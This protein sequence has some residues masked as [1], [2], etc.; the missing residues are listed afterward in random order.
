[1]NGGLDHNVRRPIINRGIM[2]VELMIAMVLGL[3]VIAGVGS[4]FLANKQAYQ[5]SE[6]LS[7]YQENVRY[8][9]EMITKDIRQADG[10]P[11][12]KRDSKFG[13]QSSIIGL[14]WGSGIRGYTSNESAESKDPPFGTGTADRIRGTDALRVTGSTGKIYKVTQHSGDVFSL[15]GNPNGSF[16]IAC[17][18]DSATVFKATVNNSTLTDSS[19]TTS[20]QYLQDSQI[21]GFSQAFWYLGC[22]GLASCDSADGRSIYRAKNNLASSGGESPNPIVNGVKSLQFEYL[23]KG[24]DE[25]AE[26]VEYWPSVIAVRVSLDLFP[27]K[28]E[29]NAGDLAQQPTSRLT[30]VIGLRNRIQP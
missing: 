25:Y 19:G 24:A 27:P 18:L 23:I 2:L 22:N 30:H 9:F 28:S 1:M 16:F 14:D 11:C 17:S 13:P 4:L 3:L 7:E 10:T 20:G 21:S 12:R 8:L 6:G 5:V 15:D 29:S 26:T